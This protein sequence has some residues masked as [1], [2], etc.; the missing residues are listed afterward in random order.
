MVGVPDFFNGP[1]GAPPAGAGALLGL[2]ALL[3]G[4]GT[5][6][7]RPAVA[8]AVVDEA[9]HEPE[10]CPLDEQR[11]EHLQQRHLAVLGPRRLLVVDQAPDEVEDPLGDLAGGDPQQQPDRREDGLH[12]P[13]VRRPITNASSIAPPSTNGVGFSRTFATSVWPPA[14]APAGVASVTFALT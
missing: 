1:L 13:A 2:G 4:P 9:A 7:P 3:A 5:G 10:E 6:E 11:H 12:G 8:A 14:W